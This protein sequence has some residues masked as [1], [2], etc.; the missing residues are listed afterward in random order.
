MVYIVLLVALVLSVRPGWSQESTGEDARKQT[1]DRCLTASRLEGNDGLIDRSHDYISRA[2]CE[3]AFWFDRFF[4]GRYYDETARPSTMLRFRS[5]LTYDEHGD[6][7]LRYNLFASLRLPSLEQRFKIVI[8]A[9]GHD[10]SGVPLLDANKQATADGVTPEEP[11]QTDP[12]EDEALRVGVRY[13]LMQWFRHRVSFD[14][15]IRVSVPPKAYMRLYYLHVR[16]LGPL[17]TLNFSEKLFWE[18]DSQPGE[19]TSLD[20]DRRISENAVIRMGISVTARL[21]QDGLLFS[22]GP[23]LYHRLS[24]KTALDYYA[25]MGGRTEPELQSRSYRLATVLRRNVFRSWMFFEVEPATDW[26]RAEGL[27]SFEQ[28]NS[29]TFRL[30]AQF[31]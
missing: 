24:A 8:Q 29:I 23:H 2:A 14:T 27:K 12:L 19:T 28:I 17:S 20:V 10:S 4:S 3:Q 6:T 11:L 31:Y 16:P 30:E 13:H 21:R 9:R 1:V 22:T 15:G 25:V 26:I 5:G 18:S 7:T